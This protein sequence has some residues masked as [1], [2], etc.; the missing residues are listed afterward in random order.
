MITI[1][2][3]MCDITTLTYDNKQKFLN[4]IGKQLTVKD[5]AIIKKSYALKKYRN[6]WK[7]IRCLEN[8]LGEDWINDWWTN[9]KITKKNHIIIGYEDIILFPDNI[10]A[11]TN[12]DRHGIEW[13]AI[14]GTDCECFDAEKSLQDII[15]QV[16]HHNSSGLGEWGTSTI[17]GSHSNVNRIFINIDD[18]KYFKNDSEIEIIKKRYKK[19]YI[20]DNYNPFK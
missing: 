19:V 2:N 14:T 17:G 10:H 4:E 13:S 16:R 15:E 5:L 18:L 12:S 11:L 9:N 6:T 1:N 7:T 3:K 20:M 8:D